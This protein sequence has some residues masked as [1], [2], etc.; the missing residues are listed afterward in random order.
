V[1]E[2]A[3]LVSALD[4]HR[5]HPRPFTQEELHP[6]RDAVAPE[7]QKKPFGD[8]RSCAPRVQ[9]PGGQTCCEDGMELQF[10]L[11]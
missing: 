11:A 5:H 7:S 10:S 1:Q 6:H 3:T 9:R 4:A 2:G 8:V